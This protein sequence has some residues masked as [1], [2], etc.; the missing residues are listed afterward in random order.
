MENLELKLIDLENR[1]QN[2]ILIPRTI[3]WSLI[4]T[5]FLGI[6]SN[7]VFS[8]NSVRNLQQDVEV[9]KEKFIKKLEIVELKF[10]KDHELILA[11]RELFNLIKDELTEIK[12]ELKMK[13][14]KKWVE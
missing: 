7:F 12:T 10:D 3:F 13:Q 1:V 8:W 6:I 4:V 5:V 2:N 14:N 9:T 11:N